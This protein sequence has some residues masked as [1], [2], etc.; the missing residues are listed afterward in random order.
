MRRVA[1][2]AAHYPP[3]VGGVERYTES[4][5]SR[6]AGRGWQVLVVTADTAGRVPEAV[7]PGAPA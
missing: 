4:L 1:V 7:P 5:W 6:M 3:H 2:F